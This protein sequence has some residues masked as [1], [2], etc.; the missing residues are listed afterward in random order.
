MSDYC[1]RFPVLQR[2]L[3]Q[4]DLMDQMM[5]H[6]RVDP[7]DVIRRDKGAS[8]YEARTRCIEC[9]AVSECRTWLA[10]ADR[11]APASVPIFCPNHR[12]FNARP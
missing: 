5:Q 4:A 10:G 3:Q 2:V 6:A 12:L 8:W 11:A 7:V 1:Y 9:P